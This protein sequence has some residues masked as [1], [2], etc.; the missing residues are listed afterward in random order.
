[1]EE[2]KAIIKRG[3]EHV[4]HTYNRT[5]VCFVS[6]EGSRLTDSDG[7][8]YLDLVAGIAVNNLGYR[9]PAVLAA[10]REQADQLIHISN[11]YWNL[12]Q[13]ELAEKLCQVSE[14]DKAFFCNSGAEANESAIK[15]ARKW[16]GDRTHII[17]LE[18]SFH[19]RTI[20][21]LTATGQP[22][23]HQ[24]FAPLPGGFSYVPANDL[25]AME[26]AIQP[27]TCAVLLE[28]V[29]GEGGVV[30]LTEAYLKGV[31]ELCRTHDLLF[32]IDEVQTGFGRTGHAFAFQAMALQPDVVTLA[33]ALASGLPMGAML[34][35]GRASEAFVPGDH[36]STFGGNPLSAH[37]ACAVA[38]I[39][40]TPAFLTEVEEK[41][42]YFRTGLMTLQEKYRETI[43]EIRGKGLMIGI[44][45]AHP[46]APVVQACLENG[47]VVGTA[48]AN[49][50]RFVPPLVI[51]REEIDEALTIL[52][53]V[54]AK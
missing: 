50:L 43:K 29:Q 4:M 8:S 2:L 47:L 19:G 5:P 26:A 41:G 32:M 7:K 37:V 22:Q 6:G 45:F 35:G 11:L 27:Q 17:T 52:E 15:L 14:L 39:I 51:T 36:A 46:V 28:V 20:G 30:P 53:G 34:T 31:Q 9:H 54:I 13:I 49:V 21:A 16:G 23:Y 33:K 3:T 42:A 44:D 10:I 12:P 25:A 38:E 48:G 1:M 40:F 18:K 24:G